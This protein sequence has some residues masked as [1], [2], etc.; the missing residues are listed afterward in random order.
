MPIT[1]I[2]A[3]TPSN[4]KY[5]LGSQLPIQREMSLMVRAEFSNIFNRTGLNIPTSSNALLRRRKERSDHRSFGY[6]LRRQPAE[7]VPIRRSYGGMFATPP[8]RQGTLVI[9]LQ[10]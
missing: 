7:M 4:R 5:E 1:T 2:T 8:P 3:A 10:F 9:R 6:S